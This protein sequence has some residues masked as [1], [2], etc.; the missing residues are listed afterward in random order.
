Y[1]YPVAGVEAVLLASGFTGLV[2]AHRTAGCVAAVAALACAFD[3]Y[4]IHFVSVP[5]YTGLTAHLHSGLIASFHPAAALRDIGL[6][7]VFAVWRSTNRLRWCPPFS[8]LY[9]SVIF[10]RHPAC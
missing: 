7:D 4:T 9:G 3:L 1:L 2:G 10:A 8:P 5:F 6:A